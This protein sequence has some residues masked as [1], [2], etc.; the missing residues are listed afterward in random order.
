LLP[1]KALV[2]R[3][4][5]R[6]N[7]LSDTSAHDVATRVIG[8]IGIVIFLIAACPFRAA[9]TLGRDATTV[10][11]DRVKMQGALLAITQNDRFAVHQLQSAAGTTIREYVST[12]GLVFAVSWEGPWLPDLQQMLGPYFDAYQRNAAATRNARR[13]HGPI[14]IRTGEMVIEVGG[15]PRAFTGRAYIER[16]LPQGVPPAAI[17]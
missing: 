13:S 6:S 11:A 14:T 5:G 3:R 1:T 10:D 17:R 4:V 7:L 15:H 9:A 12:T 2:T 8:R 16:L